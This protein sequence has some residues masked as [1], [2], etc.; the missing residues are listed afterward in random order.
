M[1]MEVDSQVL[2]VRPKPDFPPET[3]FSQKKRTPFRT[4]RPPKAP[5]KSCPPVS[6]I[7]RENPA[8]LQVVSFKSR[9]DHNG[10]LDHSMIQV[11]E[12]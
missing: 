2:G 3:F 12:C 9:I 5:A 4:R 6:R 1:E 11:Y 10:K 8:T 7:F